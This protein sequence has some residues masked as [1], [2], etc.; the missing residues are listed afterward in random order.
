M[1]QALFSDLEDN[2]EDD[3]EKTLHYRAQ[4]VAD[5]WTD[6]IQE[7]FLTSFSACCRSYGV[8]GRVVFVLSHK[9]ID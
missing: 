9:R 7:G 1:R 4:R 8:A 3:H 2:P 5:F 6:Q